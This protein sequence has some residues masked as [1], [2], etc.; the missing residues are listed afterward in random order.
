[1]GGLVLFQVFHVLWRE[2]RSTDVD[3]SS[4]YF[5]LRRLFLSDHV[6]SFASRGA[7]VHTYLFSLPISLQVVALEPGVAKDHA[8]LSETRDNEEHPFRVGFIAKDYVYHFGDLTSLIR[9]AVHVVHQYGARDA[10]GANTFHTDKVLIYKVAYSF[11]VQK[12]LDRMHLAGVCGM[13]FYWKDNRHSVSVEGVGREF[14][15]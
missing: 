15:G 7:S 3:G 13:D 14:F 9:G 2:S 12:R 4:L 6:T 10:L 11:G 1:M 5:P 8:L